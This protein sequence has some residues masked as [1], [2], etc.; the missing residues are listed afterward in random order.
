MF[1]VTERAGTELQKLLQT[2]PHTKEN[3]VIYFQ[4]FG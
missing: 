2:E 4:G 3:L 1:I